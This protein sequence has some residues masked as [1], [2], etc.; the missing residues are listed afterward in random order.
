MAEY[1]SSEELQRASREAFVDKAAQKRAEE[2]QTEKQKLVKVLDKYIEQHSKTS[3]VRKMA[4]EGNR[5]ADAQLDLSA[6]LVEILEKIKKEL[7]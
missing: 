1:Q 7:R 6:E 5:S 2:A 4:K 3:N